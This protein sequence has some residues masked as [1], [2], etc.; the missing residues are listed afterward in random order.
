MQIEF[1]HQDAKNRKLTDVDRR[2]I[3]RISR[4]VGAAARKGKLLESTANPEGVVPELHVVSIDEIPELVKEDERMALKRKKLLLEKISGPLSVLTVS[5]GL[6]NELFI[7]M[8]P[9]LISR[10]LQVASLTD[11]L[12]NPKRWLNICR[13][14][15]ESVVKVLPQRYGYSGCLDDAIACVGSRVHQCLIFEEDQKLSCQRQVEKDYL[16]ALRSLQTKLSS[17]DGVSWDV[18]YAT[19]LLCLFE[20]LEDNAMRNYICHARGGFNVLYALGPTNIDSEEAKDLLIAQTEIMILEA[21]FVDVDC[22]LSTPE[23]QSALESTIIPHV[24]IHDR[25]EAVVSL[26]KITSF[27]PVLFKK[28]TNAVMHRNLVEKDTIVSELHSLLDNY[29]DWSVKWDWVLEEEH[30]QN[31]TCG[32]ARETYL[33][34]SKVLTRYLV[35]LAMVNRFLIAIDPRSASYAESAAVTA[36]KWIAQIAEPQTVDTVPGVG[37]KLAL[38]LGRSILSTTAQWSQPDLQETIQPEIFKSWCDMIGRA[39]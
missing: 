17:P 11:A 2:T 32:L 34:R 14:A 15:Q 13:I 21:T 22:F 35:Y 16:R 27:A 12:S 31:T 18:W 39:T 37:M 23:W 29:T 24:L 36:A 28:V 20:L 4:K 25:S 10:L 8:Q 7:L 30:H 3:R 9:N 19:L 1:I 33:R 26:W 38:L 5:N 6:P